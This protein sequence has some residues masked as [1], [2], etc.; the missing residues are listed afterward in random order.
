MKTKPIPKYGGFYKVSDTGRVWTCRVPGRRK[1]KKGPWRE[2]TLSPHIRSG[3]LL[4]GLVYG[5]QP[6]TR[7]VHQLVLEAFV[8][9][10]PEGMECRHFPDRN[11]ANNNLE[12]LQWA[13]YQTNQIDRTK[14][15]T[16]NRGERCAASKLIKNQ[17]LL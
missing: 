17:V 15:G 6:K 16:S 3:H 12:N 11:P 2:M 14:H 4:V 9:P 10:C 1:D 8:G 13:T 7:Y 5:D